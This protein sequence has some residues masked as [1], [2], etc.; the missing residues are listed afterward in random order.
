MADCSV[1][2]LPGITGLSKSGIPH[3]PHKNILRD[4]SVPFIDFENTVEL[5]FI[6]ENSS[7]MVQRC[8]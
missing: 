2:G 3:L 1:A 7:E 8:L 4:A 6:W 5:V